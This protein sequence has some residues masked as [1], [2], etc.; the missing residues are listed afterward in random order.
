MGMERMQGAKGGLPGAKVGAV[1]KPMAIRPMRRSRYGRI[2][3]V[4]SEV[5][6]AQANRGNVADNLP[7]PRGFAGPANVLLGPKP[8]PILWSGEGAGVGR[9]PDW[10]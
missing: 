2:R 3:G 7:A 4:K 5:K 1:A 6:A 9:S 8:R 10:R